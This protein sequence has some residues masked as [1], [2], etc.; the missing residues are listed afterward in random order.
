MKPIY[1]PSS[2]TCLITLWGSTMSSSAWVAADAF[3]AVVACEDL[4]DQWRSD[5][6]LGTPT[7]AEDYRDWRRDRRHRVSEQLVSSVHSLMKKRHCCWT[8]APEK[9]EV[10][11]S[12]AVQPCSNVSYL[13]AAIRSPKIVLL[14]SRSRIIATRLALI[15]IAGF[16]AK[17]GRT[18]ARPV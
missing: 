10:M 3:S 11:P 18:I 6:G 17:L 15:E 12:S 13:L 2:S 14:G 1:T 4:S 9:N 8:A 7:H 16:W 5:R